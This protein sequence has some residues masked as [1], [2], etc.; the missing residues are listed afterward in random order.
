MQKKEAYSKKAVAQY[1]GAFMAWVI[2]AGFATGQE[3][4]R[5]FA[6]FGPASYGVLLLSGGGF[7][8]LARIFMTTG[9]EHKNECRFDPF[10]YFCAE[11]GGSF[12]SALVL[13]T[14]ILLM[15][16]LISGAGATLHETF[17]LPPYLGSAIMATAV[18]LAY[19]QGFDRMVRLVSALGPLIIAFSLFVGLFTL[20]RDG[21]RV[22]LIPE[23]GELL[24]HLRAAPYGALSGVLYLS[25]NFLS[26]SSYFVALGRKAQYRREAEYGA[27]L[28]ALALVMAMVLMNTAILLHAREIASLDIPVLYLAKR[29]SPL[30]GASFS[31][32]LLL[33]MF[34]SCSAMM[35]SVCS[36]FAR[37]N[38]RKNRWIA[39]TLIAFTF[40]LGLFSF[41]DLLGFFYPFVGYLGLAFLSCVFC[42]SFKK[43]VRL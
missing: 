29:I 34:S 8:V 2:G 23:A 40:T 18:L 11:K 22:R 12:Y 13:I 43:S 31:L 14:L 19:L 20:I 24:G 15:P 36:R 33:G 39:V 1:A 17:G 42:K 30:L 27:F 16:V 7:L 4:L 26:G 25:L 10:K 35:W 38:S 9:F 6:S 3:V 41:R 5:F 21:E 28:G 32:V 37:D